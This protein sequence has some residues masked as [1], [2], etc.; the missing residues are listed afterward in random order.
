METL[1]QR[2]ASSGATRFDALQLGTLEDFWAYDPQWRTAEVL[3][4]PTPVLTSPRP[5][6]FCP[7]ALTDAFEVDGQL[8]LD[9]LVDVPPDFAT[10]VETR[11][12]SP[13]RSLAGLSVELSSEFVLDGRELASRTT[14]ETFEYQH[15]PVVL[16]RNWVGYRDEHPLPLG[17]WSAPF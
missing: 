10:S 7:V 1:T 16:V 4:L 14:V 12:G 17:P 8:E 2:L 5:G 6:E 11:G 13:Q 15:T 9:Y 3:G